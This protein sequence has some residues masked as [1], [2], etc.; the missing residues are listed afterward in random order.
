MFSAIESLGGKKCEYG[1][2][3]EWAM[4]AVMNMMHSDYGNVLLPI[5]QG[6]AYARTCYQMAVAWFN[7]RDH[8]HD[9]REY[10]GL[11]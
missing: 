8:R 6:E 5:V 10:F 11:M 4:Y 2:Y 1:K 3:N 9:V 7:D